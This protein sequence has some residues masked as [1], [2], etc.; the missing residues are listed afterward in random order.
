MSFRTR[1]ML[2]SLTSLVVGLGVLLIAGNLLF[3][4]QVRSETSRLLRAHAQTQIAAL[5]VRD[6]AVHVRE[7]ANDTV[8]DKQAWVFSGARVLERPAGISAALDAAANALHGARRPVEVSGPSNFRLRAEPV[9]DGGRQVATVVVAESTDALEDLRE[10]VLVGSLVVA[11]LALL[12]GWLAVRRA[13]HGALRPVVEMTVAADDWGAHDLEHRFGLG[14]PRD[15][16]TGLAATLDG[17]LARIAS[18]RR[19]EQ[20]FASDVAHELR[21]PLAGLRARAELALA[22]GAGD[23][24]REA[25]L[26][27]VVEQTERLAVTIDTLMAVARQELGRNGTSVDAEELVRELEGVEVTVRGPVPH[28]EG[29]ADI[30]RRALAPIVDNARRHARRR[31]VVELSSDATDVSIVVRDDGPGVAPGLAE[32]IFEPGFQGEGGGDAGLGLPLARRLAQACGGDVTAGEGPGG[33]FVLT[34]PR[35]E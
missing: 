3:A 34:L 2:T 4:S 21:T 22:E 7:T 16:L 12:A 27:A 35:A 8:L 9:L 15:E 17:L 23:A 11:A 30:A 25:A 31:I 26:R 18:S 1:L 5:V 33:C 13:V 14:P 10:E 32:R 19:H 24:E 28:A 20:R 6:G 29:D